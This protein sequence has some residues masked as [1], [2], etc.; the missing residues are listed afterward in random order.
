MKGGNTWGDIVI[1]FKHEVL[2][3][4]QLL[5]KDTV[6]ECSFDLNGIEYTS[7]RMLQ[8]Q[9]SGEMLSK[10]YDKNALQTQE[11]QLNDKI[12]KFY[13]IADEV[14][15]FFYIN[16]QNGRPV[17]TPKKDVNISDSAF[18]EN[19]LDKTIALSSDKAAQF[20]LKTRFPNLYEILDEKN[21][22]EKTHSVYHDILRNLEK[23]IED[24]YVAIM[25]DLP[26]DQR[27]NF[28]SDLEG[29][30]EKNNRY[31]HA[32]QSFCMEMQANMQ[33]QM[34]QYLNWL[35]VPRIEG[36]ERFQQGEWKITGSDSIYSE[37]FLNSENFNF[38][39]IEKR[40]EK[41][42]LEYKVLPANNYG[43]FFSE[44]YGFRA[45]PDVF[46]YRNC[47]NPDEKLFDGSK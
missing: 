17:L 2:H 6:H 34:K 30:Y 28:R 37:I 5:Q 7:Q 11:S 3:V 38:N 25:A 42:T 10:I 14:E 27:E 32:L 1:D 4:K 15:K 22:Q 29:F 13:D 47:Q 26:P 33:S 35:K 20:F 12:N 8:Y 19:F 16:F 41:Y 9:P 45:A 21:Y 44:L 40:I 24:Q 31:G 36:C 46:H 18:I 43:G 23:N 39:E